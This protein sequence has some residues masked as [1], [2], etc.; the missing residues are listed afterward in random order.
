MNSDRTEISEGIQMEQETKNW[1]LVYSILPLHS[2]WFVA[3]VKFGVDWNGKIQFTPYRI[4][5]S[6]SFSKP[7][8]PKLPQIGQTGYQC[9]PLYLY[10]QKIQL[11]CGS[12]EVWGRLEQENLVYTLP[13]T[14]Q[15]QLFQTQETK[16]TS[17]TV[18]QT[19]YILLFGTN[20][21]IPSNYIICVKSWQKYTNLL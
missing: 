3:V 16:T 19:V 4:L 11:V 17:D 20:V 13:N 21:C 8:R 1:S 10:I 2:S 18:L 6:L 7:R 5:C 14:V 9:T 12:S 15:P